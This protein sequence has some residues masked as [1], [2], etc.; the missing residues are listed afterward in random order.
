MMG[1]L[2]SDIL[3]RVHL[4]GALIFRVDVCGPWC[5]QANPSIDRFSPMLARSSNHV[6]AFHVVVDGSCWIRRGDGEWLEATAGDA[7]VLPHGGQHLLGDRPGT[8]PVP[9]YSVLGEHRLADL[10]HLRLETGASPSVSI[11]CGF[12]GCDR[13]AFEPL[14]ASLPEVFRVAL[15]SGPASLID[16]ARH[17]VTDD[18]PGAQSVRVRMAELLFVEALRAYLQVLPGDARGWLAALRDPLVG[19]ALRA[20]HEQ[21]CREWSVQALAGQVASSR[22][23]L[24]ERFRDV[25]GEPPMRYLTRLRMQ[26]AADLLQGGSCTVSGV[27]EEVGY[28]SCAAFQRAFKRH[29]K[30]PPGSWREQLLSGRPR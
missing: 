15:A 28:E 10:R 22:S 19:R 17:Q 4:N 12:L 6:I 11:L 30:V 25:L 24:A 13:R 5:V 7:V 29:Y 3:G 9:F 14:F 21:P 27:A 16:H 18:S 1:D 26:M 2:L 8:D 20:M 23:R